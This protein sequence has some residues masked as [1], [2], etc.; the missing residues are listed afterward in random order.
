MG[1]F[2]RNQLNGHW[3]SNTPK[4]IDSFM[5]GMTQHFLRAKN[6]SEAFS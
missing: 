6:G 4:R 5:Y 3:T 1:D 2:G